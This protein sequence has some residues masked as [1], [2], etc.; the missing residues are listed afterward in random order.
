MK[1]YFSTPERTE[2]LHRILESWVGTPFK[3]STGVKGVG[4]DCIHL[5]LMAFIEAG[6]QYSPVLAPYSSDSHLHSNVPVMLQTI[7]NYKNLHSVK[8]PLMDGDIVLMLSGR[9]I[10][11]V[12]VYS[13]GGLYHS[14]VKAGIRRTELRDRMITKFISH[15]F[16]VME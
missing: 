3:H 11:H 2:N 16:R 8:G 10:S 7:R 6:L 15:I 13:R 9:T 1:P 5:P 12:G 14:I 4:C